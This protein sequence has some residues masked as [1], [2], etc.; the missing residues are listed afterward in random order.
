MGII[1]QFL[2]IFVHLLVFAIVY[3]WYKLSKTSREK[4]LWTIMLPLSGFNVTYAIFEFLH[5][6]YF[7]IR[8]GSQ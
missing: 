1:G 7:T 3:N 5:L 4:R 8:G 2:M 6:I